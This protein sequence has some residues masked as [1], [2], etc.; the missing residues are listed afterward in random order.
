MTP[1]L[2]LQDILEAPEDVDIREEIV[3]I[4]EEIVNAIKEHMNSEA[5]DHNQLN[6]VIQNIPEPAARQPCVT[7]SLRSTLEPK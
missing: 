6:A 2:E 4:K 7:I 5:P 1:G 3:D